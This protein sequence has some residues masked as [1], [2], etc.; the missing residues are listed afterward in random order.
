[1]SK[2]IILLKKEI[3]DLITMQTIIPII[4]VVGI[5][6]LMGS[7]MGDMMSGLG[8]PDENSEASA[9]NTIGV[10]DYDK[11]EGS[12][13]LISIINQS[14]YH[15]FTPSQTDPAEAY[16]VNKDEFDVLII[17][18]E[19]FGKMFTGESSESARV[20]V[21]SNVNSFAMTSMIG[22]SVVTSIIDSI[23]ETMS[24]SIIQ[25][26]LKDN[27]PS[28]E[29]INNPI[30][31]VEFTRVNGEIA[32]VPPSAIV[33]IVT[34]QTMF[35]PLVIFM[36][37]IFSSQTLAASV[38]N[39][40]ADKTF[41]TLL[42]TPVK[43]TQILV[44]KMVSA[45]L[46]SLIY[47]VIFLLSYDNMS[48]SMMGGAASEL[49]DLNPV[50][51][52]LGISFNVSTYLIFGISLFCAILIGLAFSIIIG[53]LAEDMKQL[54]SLLT[55]I[56]FGM[57]IPYL[58]SMFTDI[59]TLPIYIKIPLYIIPFTHTFT[60]V[61]NVFTSNYLMLAIGIGYQVIFLILAIAFATN[62]FGSD[63]LFTL[64]I[65]FGKKK[66]PINLIKLK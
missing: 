29:F 38:T 3:K 23:N 65:N 55:P 41:E 64:K 43:R 14:G 31:T 35:I 44:A 24:Q 18:P 12:E 66:K 1:M 4:L 37:V 16:N 5:F 15:I 33:S 11:S 34:S 10:I 42:T 50:L 13:Y 59:N 63:K 19:G 48:S 26:N 22:G 52:Q 53:I 49:S 9:E 40:K 25:N 28:L 20:D 8:T 46:I 54:Q 47:A 36:I 17:I 27:A 60:A 45:S 62:I 57:M 56:I 61:T 2:F 30:Q 32:E 51:Q 58:I 21:Y 7:F 39:E 6:L